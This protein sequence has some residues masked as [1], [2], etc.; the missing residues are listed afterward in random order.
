MAPTPSRPLPPA[1]PTNRLS[2]DNQIALDQIALALPNERC[3]DD[4]PE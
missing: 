3:P 2:L 1:S 4:A